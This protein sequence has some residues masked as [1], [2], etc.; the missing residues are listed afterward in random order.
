MKT[1]TSLLIAL[2]IPLTARCAAASAAPLTVAVFD[3]EP[4]DTLAKDLGAKVAILITVELSADPD[5][6]TVE[7]SELQKVLSEHEMG[8][9]GTIDNDSRAKLGHLTGAKI[10]ITGRLVKVENQF[11]IVA[12]IIGVET[13]RVVAEM[14][15]GEADRTTD[16]AA[17]LAKKVIHTIKQKR[18]SW[19][20]A[21]ISKADRL[22][23]LRDSV[24]GKALPSVAVNI[25]ENHIGQPV[26]DPAAETELLLFLEK[27]GF[28]IVDDKSQQKPDI[29]I[30]G[31]A[32][33]A[34]GIRKGALVA[35]RA[36]VEIKIH[37]L[38]K[39]ELLLVDRETAVAVDLTEPTAAKSALQNAAAEIAERILPRLAQ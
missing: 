29:Q 4:S 17:E 38:R 3:F 25:V 16:L 14:V 30:S 27:C 11:T 2:L 24:K 26:R 33:S 19:V 12:K 7:R 8:L 34:L 37:D 39:R 28:V 36:R 20:A 5:L 21:E 1:L 22:T 9:S 10:L 23:K 18:D 13:S 15:K 6:I 35:C 32:F 31:E